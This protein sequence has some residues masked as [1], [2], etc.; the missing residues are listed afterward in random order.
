M[1]R[2][3]SVF[4]ATQHELLTGGKVF[5]SRALVLNLTTGELRK[6]TASGSSTWANMTPVNRADIVDITVAA[7]TTANITIA[8]ALNNGDTLDGVTL[9]TGD[10]VLVKDQSTGHQNGIYVVGT[11]PARAAAFD[12]WAEHV[13]ILVEVEDG[14]ANADTCWFNTNTTTGTLD[15]TSITFIKQN[16]HLQHEVNTLP[17]VTPMLATDLVVVKRADGSL[18]TVT[19]AVLKTYT[20]A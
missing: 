10:L 17:A 9:A 20:T 13:G 2:I 18:A 14:T 12:T 1:K 15:T 6:A 5:A 7:A 4:T 16:T 3:S 8:T 11:T 19:G